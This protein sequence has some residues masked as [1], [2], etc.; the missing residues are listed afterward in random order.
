M[1][2][3]ANCRTQIPWPVPLS[4]TYASHLPSVEMASEWM[5][6]VEVRGEMVIWLKE[7]SERGARR[8]HTSA[9]KAVMTMI[10]PMMRGTVIQG[11]VWRCAIG[12][13][14]A[15]GPDATAPEG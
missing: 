10:A 8:R 4:W 7:G 15:R 12:G 3:V 11:C 9:A 13:V 2:P 5:L 1:L 6:P 14:A